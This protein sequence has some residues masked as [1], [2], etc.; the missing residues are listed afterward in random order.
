[1]QFA[2]MLPNSL[3]RPSGGGDLE[4]FRPPEIINM[5]FINALL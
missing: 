2:N 1:M 3:L 4:D 5:M